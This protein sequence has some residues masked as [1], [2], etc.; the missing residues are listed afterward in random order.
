MEEREAKAWLF[1]GRIFCLP[2]I[3]KRIDY[4][5]IRTYKR[6]K[7]KWQYT[8]KTQLEIE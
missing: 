2:I 3:S 4:K 6:V 8:S 1:S 5:A 7:K